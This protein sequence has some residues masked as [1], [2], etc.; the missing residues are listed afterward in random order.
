MSIFFASIDEL[1]TSESN[2]SGSCCR[3]MCVCRL[4]TR[5]LISMLLL[6]ELLIDIMATGMA[7][8]CLLLR[9][10]TAFESIY[11]SGAVSVGRLSDPLLLLVCM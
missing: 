10:V 5:P 2:D 3:V 9:K 8:S 4:Y 6:D 7:L 1:R 11:K